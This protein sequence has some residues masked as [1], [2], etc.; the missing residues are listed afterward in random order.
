MG[1]RSNTGG[2][3]SDRTYSAPQ[4]RMFDNN[5]Q[6]PSQMPPGTGSLPMP[7]MTGNP[8]SG[9]RSNPYGNG[10]GYPMQMAGFQEAPNSNMYMSGGPPTRFYDGAP[11]VTGIQESLASRDYMGGGLLGMPQQTQV[12]GMNPNARM[13]MCG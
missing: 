13:S 2:S 3:F 11:K 4:P 9:V 8:Y 5:M 12:P 1:G 7:D 10:G 6:A